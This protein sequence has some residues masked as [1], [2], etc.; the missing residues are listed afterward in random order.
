MGDHLT[1]D[2]DS[3]EE[4]T[5]YATDAPLPTPSPTPFRTPHPSRHHSRHATPSPTPSGYS[6]SGSPPATNGG[7]ASPLHRINTGHQQHSHHHQ[8]AFDETI[9]ILDP[10]RF[11]P[12]L[13]AN[14]VAEI[15]S[16]RRELEAKSNWVNTLEEDL[17]EAR[18]EHE[19]AATTAVTAQREARDIK[20]QLARAENDDA[21]EIVAKERDEA[22]NTVA[23][24]KRQVERLT[25][26]RR[27][28]EEDV[29]RMKKEAEQEREEFEAIKRALERK[30]HVAEG[31]LKSVL[32][33]VAA[34]NSLPP[35][36]PPP[37]E[38][39][40]DHEDANQSEIE[41]SDAASIQE[42]MR[43]SFIGRPT[44]W[45]MG[46]DEAERL[47]IRFSVA[48]NAGKSLADELNFDDDEDDEEGLEEYDEYD[49]DDR[50]AEFSFAEDTALSA[51]GPDNGLQSAV[52]ENGQE[53]EN[54]MTAY[55]EM[56]VQ[57]DIDD[58]QEIQEQESKEEQQQL[59]QESEKQVERLD[60]LGLEI[61][62]KLAELERT[63]VEL[64][65]K[66]QEL[67]SIYNEVDR[68]HYRIV[69]LEE[70]VDK[71]DEEAAEREEFISNLKRD[72]AEEIKVFEARGKEVEE[73]WT[74][75]Q[76]QKAALEARVTSLDEREEELDEREAELDDQE[77]VPPP[78]PPRR[79][80]PVPPMSPISP[81]VEM[82][83]IGVQT[84]PIRPPP[85]ARV[86]PTIAVI[87]PPP[88]PPLPPPPPP[89]MKSAS[90]QTIAKPRTRSR[91][92]Q[93]EEIR[94]DERLMKIA[95]HLHPSAIMASHPP[96]RPVQ[97]EDIPPSPPKKSSRRSMVKRSSTMGPISVTTSGT[98]PRSVPMVDSG[99][100]SAFFSSPPRSDTFMQSPDKELSRRS[101]GYPDVPGSSG[102]EFLDDA[103]LSV[104]EF[105]TA[106]SAPKSKK[107]KS[108]PHANL[109]K[110][111]PIETSAP[112]PGGG[113]QRKGATI[114]KTAL[115]SSGSQAHNR[116]R[117]PS[118]ESNRTSESGGTKIGPPFPVP[119]RHSSRKPG[120]YGSHPRNESPTPMPI[121]FSRR[122]TQPRHQ[123][124][125][126][127]QSI[128]KVRSATALPSLRTSNGR[129]RSPPPL[130]ASSIAPDSPMLPF[131]RDEIRASAFERPKHG[132]IKHK[133]VE[134]ITTSTSATTNGNASV[135]STIQQTSVVDAIAQTMV[136]EWM[137]KYVRRRKSFGVAES[138]Q[139]DDSAGGQRHKRWVWLAP[140]ERAVMW[141]SRQPTSGNALLGKSGRKLPIQSVLDVKD[142]TPLPKGADPS[143]PLFNRSILILTPARALKFTAP[144]KERHYVWLTALSFLSH[145][146]Q[147]S[148]GL[149]AL[150]PPM[151][152]E[153]EQVQHQQ[154]S[155]PTR[156]PV[157]PI[158]MHRDAPFHPVRDSIRLAK[159]KSRQKA[160]KVNGFPPRN[161]SIL[162]VESI[163]S[164]GSSTAEPPSIP[165]FPGQHTRKRS[166]SAVRPGTHRS[167]SNGYDPAMLSS[168]GGSNTADYYGAPLMGVGGI[169]I[170]TGNSLLSGHPNPPLG[171]WDNGPV[172]TVRMEAFVERPR[173]DFDDE[174]EYGS[175]FR[176]DRRSSRQSHWSGSIDYAGSPGLG[177][178]SN[179]EGFW[180]GEDPFSGF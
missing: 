108:T 55:H 177:P 46:D 38:I 45:K 143:K 28:A 130:S 1:V 156:P 160:A 18:N 54:E 99:H 167:I 144:N 96:V 93:T 69:E 105:K 7:R 174:E 25:K 135:G 30:V 11:T 166:S 128:R 151:P 19:T 26:S 137:W 79:G 62:E 81:A 6:A 23:E 127:V 36:Q 134:S 179:D 152:F 150:P 50:T 21:V 161:D 164:V 66:T 173:Y 9:S 2:Y 47:G 75:L 149:L 51:N 101:F 169:G 154:P 147:G 70:Q 59:H 114:R 112:K 20:R 86:I 140:Y 14:L 76:E 125:S 4:Y 17:H 88:T 82:Q 83:T 68:A 80:S 56:G 120:G 153:Y 168:F 72:H 35:P 118:F 180:R 39:I 31:R 67:D 176:R 90:A 158:P 49:E 139:N 40:E 24:L 37:P 89:V 61:E 142:E 12:T 124:E 53:E 58:T 103:E 10:R 22:V 64:D 95:P 116:P 104:N 16:L 41:Q 8:L 42:S 155:V 117:S 85:L 33:E 172:G 107:P 13:H 178:A 138:P 94:L 97:L 126:S 73:K 119:A 102:D 163:R 34:T 136:G 44:S 74:A 121:G 43:D 65:R 113:L 92:M 63:Y 129:N 3:D 162:E 145:S 175:R 84:E 77:L 71:M 48:P 52:E 109:N 87:P 110:P 159:G 146:P 111:S 148:E 57:V 131:R 123:R 91:S 32:D 78:I 132:S 5:D 122:P 60:I 29:E 100:G 106:L 133:R 15:L 171:N 98:T 170:V 141:S 165:R 115:I 157:P 27:A